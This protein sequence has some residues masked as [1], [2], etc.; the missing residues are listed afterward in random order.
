M[1]EIKGEYFISQNDNQSCFLVCFN[2]KTYGNNVV[3]TI[4]TIDHIPDG[5]VVG[6]ELALYPTDLE[7]YMELDVW[8]KYYFPSWP[9]ED[10]YQWYHDFDGNNRGNQIKSL[11]DVMEYALKRSLEIGKI[12]LY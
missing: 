4:Y 12:E 5:S 11:H 1:K 8:N 10:R 2:V 6:K 9:K 3:S 7:V